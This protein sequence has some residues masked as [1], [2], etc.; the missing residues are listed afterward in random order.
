MNDEV[1][2]LLR[3]CEEQW[4]HIRHL[5]DQRATFTNFV[6][7]VTAGVIGFIVQQGLGKASLPLTTLLV[8]VGIY[9]AIASYKFYERYR[10][11]QIREQ[12]WLTRIHELNPNA[13]L[14]ELDKVAIDKHNREFPRMSKLHVHT[15]WISFNVLIALL[16]IV[17]TIVAI[18]P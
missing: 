1:E 6:L 12:H 10:L 3:Y 13:K 17:M 4:H 14:L 8:I 2:I 16:G 5:E 18:V 11:H 15:I 9:G 7:V